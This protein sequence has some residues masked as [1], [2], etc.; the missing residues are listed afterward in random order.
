MP[1]DQIQYAVVSTGLI[2]V[3]C[4]IAVVP[5]IEKLGRKPL[6][7]FPMA[8]MLATFIGMTLCLIL[9]QT[10]TWIP[11]L[12]IFFII[13]FICCFAVGLGPIP[14]VYASEVFRQEARGA[15]LATCMTVNWTAN[16]ILTLTFLFLVELL[17][18]YVFLVF[19]V[20]VSFG[21]FIIVTKVSSCLSR[22]ISRH[23]TIFCLMHQ[24]YYGHYANNKNEIIM[25]IICIIIVHNQTVKVYPFL[26]YLFHIYRMRVLDFS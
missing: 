22:T 11:Y 24:P 16:L 26:V 20:I 13:L 5:L 7:T 2:N 21:L 19:F 14:F 18:D 17:K 25:I 1:E 9:Q 6:L 3:L 23:A 4:T 15:A 12:S 8:L 10:Y